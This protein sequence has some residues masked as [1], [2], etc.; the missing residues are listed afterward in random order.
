M[1]LVPP[2]IVPFD[3][4]SDI[5]NMNDM[6]SATCTVNKGD[7][8]L[9]LHWTTAPE[10]TLGAGRLM[11]NDGIL[12]TKTT[13]RI[14]MLSIESVHARHRANYTCVA[15]NA[16]GVAYHTAELRVNGEHKR[17]DRILLISSVVFCFG[18]FN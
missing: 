16:A 18:Y 2:Q 14:S 6:V 1:L 17:I 8:P 7:T 11:T 10:P 15:R 9:D 3:F 12:I 5:I 4:G 13:Q